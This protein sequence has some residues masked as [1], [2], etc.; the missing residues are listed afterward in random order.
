M[1]DKRSLRDTVLDKIVFPTANAIISSLIIGAIVSFLIDGKME[2]WK[3]ISSMQIEREQ[4]ARVK[5][6]DAYENAFLLIA[7][8]YFRTGTTKDQLYDGINHFGNTISA[9][10]AY[11]P[12]ELELTYK[13]LDFELIIG[14][15]LLVKE[16]AK[17]LTEQEMARAGEAKA[18]TDAAEDM[19]KDYMRSWQAGNTKKADRL[20]HEYFVEYVKP[21]IKEADEYSTVVL[22]AES[23][24]KKQSEIE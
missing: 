3:V 7:N 1:A 17:P 23:T 2:R 11:I 16:V 24:I 10:A 4:Q 20:L 5:T 21:G 6:Y 15:R 12:E 22:S 14:S 13:Y 19:L 9:Q 8:Y 18:A